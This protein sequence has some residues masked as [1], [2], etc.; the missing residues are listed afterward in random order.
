MKTLGNFNLF[1][2]DFIIGSPECNVQN[3]NSKITQIEVL[4]KWMNYK[5]SDWGM[6][7][8]RTERTQYISFPQVIDL[9]D[10]FLIIQDLMHIYKLQYP[11]ATKEGFI[12]TVFGFTIFDIG[13][14]I[15]CEYTRYGGCPN[16][17]GF[18]F[19]YTYQRISNEFIDF[20]LDHDKDFDYYKQYF[21]KVLQLIEDIEYNPIELVSMADEH[22]EIE[23]KSEQETPTFKNNIVNIT[24]VEI[25]KLGSLADERKEIET[26]SEQETSTF[27]N[28]FDNISTIEIYK[29]FKAGLVEKGYLTEYEL[30]KYLKAAFELLTV[31]EILFKLK[32]APRKS[33]DA[34]FYNYYRNVAGK[35]HGKQI[36]YAALLGNYFEGYK[37]QTVSSN[38]SKSVY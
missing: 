33:I 5:D 20:V 29:H 26:K 14:F 3:S 36:K 38:F 37:T 28:N 1:S 15:E 10:L 23:T 30:N 16:V 11:Y 27:K 19:Y 4:H 7:K 6:T 8:Y 9:Q 2:S 21:K 18:H 31:P 22:K 32:D 24:S 12:E 25:Y 35:V 34:V 17:N 13:N